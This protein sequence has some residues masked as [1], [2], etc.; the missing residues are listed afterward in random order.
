MRI[1]VRGNSAELIR[2]VYNPAKKRCIDTIVGV[3]SLKTVRPWVCPRLDSE[4]RAELTNDELKA[5]V[6]PWL[7]KLKAEISEK[8]EEVTVRRAS[9]ILTALIRGLAKHKVSDEEAV[10]I[11]SLQKEIKKA[12]AAAG[13]PEPKKRRSAEKSLSPTPPA[14]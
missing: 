2:S 9:E 10:R 6:E 3:I 4:L 13:H 8:E 11:Y 5:V 12:L 1:R 7:S 14:T